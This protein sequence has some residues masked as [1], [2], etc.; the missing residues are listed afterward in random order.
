MFITW[1]VTL[2]LNETMNFKCSSVLPILK[3]RFMAYPYRLIKSRYSTRKIHHSRTRG[4]GCYN[5]YVLFKLWLFLNCFCYSKMAAWLARLRR[6]GGVCVR[7]SVS[8]WSRSFDP[9][10]P[11]RRRGTKTPCSPWSRARWNIST[12]NTRHKLIYLL[13]GT[14][15]EASIQGE[16]R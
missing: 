9:T 4:S 8:R 16:Y 7:V 10:V 14:H 5:M 3:S 1:K 12:C 11:P 15:L 6:R 2:R 13:R